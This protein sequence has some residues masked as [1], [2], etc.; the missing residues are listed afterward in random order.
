L[1]VKEKCSLKT[2][3]QQKRNKTAEVEKYEVTK[4]EL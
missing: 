1:K 4:L 2:M 3:Y